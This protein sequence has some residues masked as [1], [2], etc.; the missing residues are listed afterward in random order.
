MA[1][2]IP[3]ENVD[4]RILRVIEASI[5]RN[6]FFKTSF[7]FQPIP[8]DEYKESPDDEVYSCTYN[9]P[10]S[11]GIGKK[12]FFEVHTEPQKYGRKAT[13]IYLVA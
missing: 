5:R 7:K 10:K 13:N 2:H 4:N 1:Q 3:I 11:L 6:R 9:V 12:G 8:Y